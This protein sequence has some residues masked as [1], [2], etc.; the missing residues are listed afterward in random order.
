VTVRS[1]I[2][3]VAALGL[4]AL[5][6]SCDSGNEK[7]GEPAGP[8]RIAFRFKDA[9]YGDSPSDIYVVNPD[10]SGRRNLTAAGDVFEWSP[11]W[12]PDGGRIAFTAQGSELSSTQIYV[13]NADGSNRRQ[14]THG[15]AYSQMG[16]WSPDGQTIFYTQIDLDGNVTS[17][18]MDADGS[19]NRRV[20][21]F[22][23]SF[24]SPDG[25][26]VAGTR[27]SG[28]DDSD[29]YGSPDVFVAKSNGEDGRWL[30]RGGDAE[31]FGWSPDSE[32]ILYKRM[33]GV[34]VLKAPGLY[35]VKHDGSG[36]KRLT[37]S[38]EYGATWSP[39]GRLILYTH[40]SKPSGIYVVDASGGTPRRVTRHVN[41]LSA[42]WSPD[43]KRILFS[44][45][46]GIW[47]VNRDGTGLRPVARPGKV[48]VYESPAW[49]PAC[50]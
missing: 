34:F 39:D 6:A 17:W 32:W 43:G 29:Y 13:M 22:Q 33:P 11:V 35:V 12:S 14:L 3:V 18:T 45:D 26:H 48:P 31:F 44:R 28:L 8:C 47:M 36:R 37:R 2:L 19:D 21:G 42:S 30:T 10:G 50:K 40:G 20:P 38:D 16:M 1:A 41:D 7:A 46:F 27:N 23:E 4:I 24:R 49:S 5:A 15:R 9:D 25:K